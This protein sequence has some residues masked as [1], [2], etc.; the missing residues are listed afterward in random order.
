MVEPVVGI[1]ISKHAGALDPA[2]GRAMHGPMQVLVKTVIDGQRRYAAPEERQTAEELYPPYG[3]RVS[4]DYERTL[5]PLEE[6]RVAILFALDVECHIAT[7]D[8]VMEECVHLIGMQEHSPRAMQDPPMKG[9]LE[10]TPIEKEE[11][12]PC[13]GA[14]SFD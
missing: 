10:Q 3:W 5:P 13:T 1:Q 2:P 6:D 12:E 11:S 9:V 7:E 4:G 8:L 14:E